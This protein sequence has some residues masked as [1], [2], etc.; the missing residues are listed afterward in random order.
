MIVI[1]RKAIHSLLTLTMLLFF[2]VGV[3]PSSAGTVPGSGNKRNDVTTH[4]FHPAGMQARH[5]VPAAKN[6]AI[7]LSRNVK[8]QIR[9][10][11]QEKA[12]RTP[13]Q[14]KIS[15]HILYTSRMLQGKPAAPGVATLD[16]GAALDVKNR[17][18]VDISADVSEELLSRL[19][20]SGVKVLASYPKYHSIRAV[21]PA[22]KVETVA[23]WSEIRRIGPKR[24]AKLAHERPARS[25]RRAR[26]RG[27]STPC[28]G[29]M[30]T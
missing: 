24:E 4:Q 14:R 29:G 16:T 26:D 13:A 6:K 22:D 8:N 17:L 19:N 20:S 7:T 11:L 23:A 10:L 5:A 30:G 1:H 2:T 9:A 3:I 27:R 15:S 12:S 28:S 18:V 25:R 21:I